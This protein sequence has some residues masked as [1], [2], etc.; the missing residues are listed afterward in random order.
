MA[1]TATAP[2][3]PMTANASRAEDR[4]TAQVPMTPSSG[5]LAVA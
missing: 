3:A 5:L 2:N 4:D 1:T